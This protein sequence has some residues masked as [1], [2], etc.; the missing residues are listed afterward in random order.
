VSRGDID[1]KRSSK[2]LTVTLDPGHY[3]VT[4]LPYQIATKVLADR[5]LTT[6]AA[7]G[8]EPHKS[9]AAR[10]ITEDSTLYNDLTVLATAAPTVAPAWNSTIVSARTDSFDGNSYLLEVTAQ[11]SE[12]TRF[13]GG[14]INFDYTDESLDGVRRIIGVQP[15]SKDADGETSLGLIHLDKRIVGTNGVTTVGK[16]GTHEFPILPPAFKFTAVAA[17]P[18]GE[19]ANSKAVA[20]ADSDFLGYGSDI[21]GIC[22][23]NYSPT[24]PWAA[25]LDVDEL[26]GIASTKDP[27]PSHGSLLGATSGNYLRPITMLP[28]Q[29]TGLL[30]T[31]TCS[32]LLKIDPSSTLFTGVLGYT[33]A[34]MATVNQSPFTHIVTGPNTSPENRG[35]DASKH[36]RL[37]R[38]TSVAFHC[39]S[40]VG[41]SYNQHGERAGAVMANV[42]IVVP[43]NNVQA[44][45]AMYDT[46]IPCNLHGGSIDTVDFY[47]TN[48]DGDNVDLMGSDF[49]ATVRLSWD[50]PSVPPLGSFGAEAESAYGLRDVIYATQQQNQM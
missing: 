39:P 23:P 13:V 19:S 41:S 42:P 11:A 28:D 6:L 47:L 4:S 45:Q 7:T 10:V 14:Y 40:L 3:D 25:A 12:L 15:Y 24:S 36:G 30:Q 18:G 22:L 27:V 2:T 31:I 44:W 29:H 34:D 48:Q 17:I 16:S 49:L 37:L 1:V 8:A 20:L 46:S 9:N 32:P 43:S 38:T 35:M 33:T 26:I 21:A 5:T 50:K